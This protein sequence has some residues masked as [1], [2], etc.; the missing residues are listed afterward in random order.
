MA[1]TGGGAYIGGENVDDGRECAQ[2][3]HRLESG[4]CHERGYGVVAN[5][6]SQDVIA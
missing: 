4:P 1:L 5:L 6:E 2:E 3:R